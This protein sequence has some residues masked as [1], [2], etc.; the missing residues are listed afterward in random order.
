M[1]CTV[2][3]NAVAQNTANRSILDPAMPSL[4]RVTVYYDPERVGDLK[5]RLKAI[6]DAE[7]GYGKVTESHVALV[8]LLQ[9]MH[10][11]EGRLGLS[12]GSAQETKRS[13]R[14]SRTG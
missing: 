3:Y 7:A 2:P 14:R 5:A 11:A 8:L 6:G 12:R 10:E 13:A 9:K 1:C 4:P